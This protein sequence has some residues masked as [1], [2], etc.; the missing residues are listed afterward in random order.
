MRER[1]KAD[2]AVAIAVAV[3]VRAEVEADVIVMAVA[4]VIA[5]RMIA[6]AAHATSA[7]NPETNAIRVTCGSPVPTPAITAVN[8]ATPETIEAGKPASSANRVTIVV[9]NNATSATRAITADVIVLARAIG[10]AMVAAPITEMAVEIARNRAAIPN[11][12]DSRSPHHNNKRQVAS[13][14]PPLKHSPA[15]GYQ[16]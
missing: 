6:P 2:I 7:A 16:E 1:L 12:R 13:S 9:G 5:G 11:D 8:R 10:P 14:M 3:V 15:L 4:S